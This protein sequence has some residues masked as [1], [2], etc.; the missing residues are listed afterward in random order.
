MMARRVGV[1]LSDGRQELVPRLEALAEDQRRRHPE[2]RVTVASLVRQLLE[3]ALRD[4][5][6]LEKT[7][8]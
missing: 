1:Y 3:L 7:K 5:S 6:I 2:R 4:P 8:R